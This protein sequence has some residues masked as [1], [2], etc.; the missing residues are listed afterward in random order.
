MKR[1]LPLP[2]RNMRAGTSIFLSLFAWLLLSFSGYAQ[3]KQATI[4]LDADNESVSSVLH[5][6]QQQGHYRFVYSNGILDDKRLITVHLKNG[7]LKQLMDIV[8]RDSELVFELKENGIVVLKQAAGKRK[9]DGKRKISGLVRDSSGIALPGVTVALKSKPGIG[10]TTDLNGGF[11]LELPADDNAVLVFTMMGFNNREIVLTDQATLNVKLSVAPR[12]LGEAV[13]VAFGKQKKTDVVGSIT[14]INPQDLK[15]PSSNLTTALAG[16]V[17]GLIAYQRSGEPGADNASFF[18]RGVTTFGYKKDPLILIDGVE[19]TSTDL[20]RLRMDDINNFSILK[21]ATAT[22]L[23][24]ARGA[25]GVILIATKQGKEGRPV[26]SARVENSWSSPTRNVEL[27]DP[28]TYMKMANEAANTGGKEIRTD[29]LYSQEKIDSTGIGS[30]Y[31][32]PAVDWRKML[33]KDYTMNQRADVNISGGASVARYYVSAGFTQDNGV[34]KV[35]KLNNFNNNINLKTYS[36]RSNVDVNLTKTTLLTTR[37]SGTFQDYTGPIEGG[38]AVY[39]RVMHANPVKF[40]AYYEPDEEHAFTKHILFGNTDPRVVNPYAEM[41]K[42]YKEY[43]SSTINAQA[44]IRQQLDF[45]TEGLSLSVMGNTRRYAYYD[46]VR[47][48]KPFYYNI[49]NYNGATGSYIL[50]PLNPDEGTEYLSFPA[51]NEKGNRQV[52]T[53]IYF[54]GILNYGRVF[55]A[56]GVSGSLV[57]QAQNSISG[58]FTSLQTS[59]PARN[60]GISGRA[61][62]NYD[63]RYFAEFNFG[64]N[65]SERFD[66]NHRF[67]FFPSAGVAWNISNEKFWRKELISTISNLKLRATYGLVGN[68]AIGSPEDRFFYMSEVTIPLPSRGATFGLPG[69]YYTRPGLAFTRFANPDITWEVAR[70]T[71]LGL[72]MSFWNKLNLTADFY[73]TYRSRIL[74]YRSDIPATSGFDA[75]NIPSAN[76]GA[77]TSKGID[78]SVDYNHK[79]NKDWWLQGRANVTL[80]MSK[81]D[82]YEEPDYKDAPWRSRIGYSLSQQWGYIAERLF[83]DEH[84]VANAPEQIFGG[85]GEQVRPGDIKYRDVNGDGKITGLDMVPIGH[86]T[87]PELVYGFGLSA[88]YKS[89]D[90]SAFFQGQGRSSFSIDTRN[91]TPFVNDNALLKAYADDHWSLENRD[92]YALWPRF[93]TG[94]SANNTQSSTWWTR[95]GRFLR[96]KQL[97]LGYSLPEATLRRYKMKS[98]RLYA[99]GSN[100]FTLSSFKLWDIEMAGNGLGYPVQRVINLGLQT[101]F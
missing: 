99:N 84:D 55:G 80:A 41:V 67:G 40:P 11:F 9:E 48:Y 100:L 83:I 97:E 93:S 7:S 98:F 86:P 30:P 21:D 47:S 61:T 89:F 57:Y 49:L 4:T 12:A 33:F 45:I 74:M 75:S 56:H 95:N 70:Q 6:V 25:N 38:A 32:Y 91:T 15:V 69:S 18:I 54:Q 66:L 24:G 35:P 92:I 29:L 52:T 78:A 26:Y 39:N 14:S 31:L 73:N 34:L 71:N 36:I 68:D 20:A 17:A 85:I 60:L 76:I 37:V 27:A 62:Y 16:R 72:D 42:G 53:S 94:I 63:Q 88:G 10:T 64:Y 23:Y 19:V 2:G 46:L 44:E 87:D 22:A 77:A 81:Y 58:D 50:N 1:Y 8:L 90:I 43:T 51:A 28:V 65:G 59:L 3:Q 82:K 79:I 13:V 101:S 5:R 96:L